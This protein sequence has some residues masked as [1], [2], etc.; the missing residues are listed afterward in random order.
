[1]SPNRLERLAALATAGLI[2]LGLCLWCLGSAQA[3]GLASPAVSTTWF[4]ANS[5][6]EGL[7]GYW[8]FD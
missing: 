1:M 5:P 7:V 6:G 8:K 4:V 3:Q 2:G